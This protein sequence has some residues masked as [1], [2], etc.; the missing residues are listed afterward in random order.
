MTRIGGIRLEYLLDSQYLEVKA[1]TNQLQNQGEVDCGTHHVMLLM[2]RYGIPGHDRGRCKAFE[3]LWPLR[4]A[5]LLS[6]IRPIIG[7]SLPPHPL[8]THLPGF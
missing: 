8:L 3:A 4:I 6:L 1:A 7:S 2:V 5:S